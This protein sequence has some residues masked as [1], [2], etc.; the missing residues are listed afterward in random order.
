MEILGKVLDKSMIKKKYNIL[1]ITLA[2]GGS[3]KIKKKNIVKIN[4][5]PL[6]Y[7]TINQ[8]IKSKLISD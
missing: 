6:I 8:A 1:G 5:K 2:R 7:Y 3:K 4:N